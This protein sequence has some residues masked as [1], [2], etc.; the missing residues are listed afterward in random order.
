MPKGITIA[1]GGLLACQLCLLAWDQGNAAGPGRMTL[2][3]LPRPAATVL[4]SDSR[5]GPAAAREGIEPPAAAK[6]PP[7]LTVLPFMTAM[8]IPEPPPSEQAPVRGVYVTAYSAGSARKFGE[9]MSFIKATEVNSVV[10]D[11][12]DDTGTISYPS[13]VELARKIGSGY[14]KFDPEQVLSLLK[15]EN[16]RPI[17]RIVVF[18]DPFLA[19]KRTDLAVRSKAGGLWRDRHGQPWVDPNCREVWRYVV[20]LAKEAA[21]KGFQEIQFDYVRFTSDGKISDCVYPFAT[22]R[23][24][25]DVIQDFLV[26]ARKELKPLGVA[27]S[28]DVFGLTCSSR[29]DLGIGQRLEQI[30]AAV[31]IISPMVYPSHYYKGT[32]GIP[33]PDLAPYETIAASLRAALPRLAGLGVRVRPWLQDF[34]LYSKYGRK[35]LMAQIKAVYD[36]GLTEWI[37]WN[38]SNNYDR[39]KYNSP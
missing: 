3:P 24:K 31:D 12:K 18:K 5:K 39:S 2:R 19:A 13:A 11:V 20:D 16:I 35:E 28:A 26:Y 34:S 23:S 6:E 10:I 15:K 7:E 36:A 37:F 8:P 32:Y 29:D 21:A 4:P 9:I 14:R 27:L 1:L 22:G 17:A 38:P 25:S 30:A 33:N